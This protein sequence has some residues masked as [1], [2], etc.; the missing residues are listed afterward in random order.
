VADP[1]EVAG[2]LAEMGE[3]EADAVLELAALAKTPSGWGKKPPDEKLS[4]ALG[5]LKKADTSALE[6]VRR[7]LD[8]VRDDAAPREAV[9]PLAR[10]RVAERLV[11]MSESDADSVLEASSLDSTPAGWDEK[12]EDAKRSMVLTMLASA[13]ESDFYRLVRVL[14][15]LEE[16]HEPTVVPEP[17]DAGEP[18]A[19]VVGQS[20]DLSASIRPPVDVSGPIFVVHGHARAILHEAVRVLERATGRDVVVL[21]EQP[22]SGRTIL[23]KFEAHAAGAAYAVVLLTADDEGGVAAD[24][25]RRLR[26]RQNVIFELGFFFGKLGRD[27]VAVLLDRNVERPSDIDGLVYITLDAAGAWEHALARELEA[28]GIPVV[29]ARIPL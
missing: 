16:T 15:S 7:I 4:I 5:I 11:Q 20:T 27:R 3:Y 18:A 26:G 10:V 28:V 24:S 1:I 13:D 29:Y 9:T 6:R 19:R 2:H 21:H 14:D 17:P 23:E 12:P 8:A 25:T 22:N